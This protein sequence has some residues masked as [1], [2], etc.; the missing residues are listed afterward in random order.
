MRQRLLEQGIC[1]EVESE[2]RLIPT[3]QQPWSISRD[4]FEKCEEY[5]AVFG[6]LF[7]DLVEDTQLLL[8]L[9]KDLVHEPLIG[10]LHRLVHLKQSHLGPRYLEHV[11][12]YGL[13]FHRVDFIPEQGVPKMVEFNTISVGMLNIMAKLSQVSTPTIG[14]EILQPNPELLMSKLVSLIP[15][16]LIVLLHHTPEPN[17]IDQCL[18]VDTFNRVATN[19]QAEV[20]MIRLSVCEIPSSFTLNTIPIKG[21]IW[22]TFYDNTQLTPDLIDFRLRVETRDIVSIPSVEY[23]LV[24]LKE[25]QRNLPH[26]MQRFPYL[27]PVSPTLVDTYP[28]DYLIELRKAPELVDD[29]VLKTQEE[30][31]GHCLSGPTMLSLTPSPGSFLMRKIKGTPGPPIHVTRSSGDILLL[32]PIIEIG[33]FL[34]GSSLPSP[35]YLARVKD[36]DT[37]EAGLMHGDGALACLQVLS[38][39]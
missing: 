10:T 26:L 25:V 2:R 31:G 36:S 37:L 12:R 9:T 7:Q 5:A 29:W 19:T 18:F 34:L 20:R 38:P 35:G 22:R 32:S 16:G 1:F 6:R 39:S 4:L 24:G 21:I 14:Y 11:R 15:T 3:C 23:Q 13:C 33:I 27:L 28:L 17:M 30:G 8:D